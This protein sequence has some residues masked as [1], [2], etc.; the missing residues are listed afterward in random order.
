[1][2]KRL[3]DF[4]ERWKRLSLF[5]F[6][7]SATFLSVVAAV[8]T[9]VIFILMGVSEEEVSGPEFSDRRLLEGIFLVCGLAPLLETLFFQKLPID[10]MRKFWAGS[11]V[12]L[13][14]LFSASLFALFHIGYSIWYPIVILPMGFLL[15]LTYETFNN[16]RESAFWVTFAVHSLRNGVALLFSYL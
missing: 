10:L 6:L 13:R 4:Y 1:M 3:T 5:P 16:R 7:L 14:V 11:T 15:A 9:A 8:P 2:M 12:W